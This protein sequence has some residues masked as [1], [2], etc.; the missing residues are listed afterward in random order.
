M[1]TEPGT[2]ALN[3]SWTVGP[4]PLPVLSGLLTSDADSVQAGEALTFSLTVWNNASVA[5]SGELF[6]LN[7]A[8]NLFESGGLVLA[9]GS[10]SNWS[11][12]TSAKPMVVSCFSTGGR[13]DTTSSLPTGIN[14]DMPSAVFES[15]GSSTPTL[16]AAL[17]TKATMFQPTFASKHGVEEGRVRLVLNV[18]SSLVKGMGGAGGWFSR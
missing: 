16:S 18:G 9:P 1:G 2:H 14:I 11:F 4:P 7:E 8:D 12:T 5:F 13:V 3:G 17:G 15:A 10:S 6:C